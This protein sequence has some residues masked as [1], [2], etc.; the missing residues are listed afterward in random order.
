MDKKLN[1]ICWLWTPLK[2]VITTKKPYSYTYKDVNN[3]Y[4]MLKRFYK[5]PFKLL[6]ITDNPEGISKDIKIIPLWDELRSKGGCFTR[7]VVFKNG[8]DKVFGERFVSIDLDCVIVDD[9]TSLFDRK[10]DFVIWASGNPKNPY[11]G[12]LWML[13]ANSRVQVYNNF[14]ANEWVPNG[15]GRFPKGTDQAQIAKVLPKASTWSEEDGIYNYRYYRDKQIPNNARIIFFNGNFHPRQAYIQKK[16]EVV[17]KYYPEKNTKSDSLNICCFYWQG[18]RRSG[19]DDLNLVSKYINNLYIGLINNLTIPF[20]F[21][22]FIQKDLKL[23]GISKYVSI[24]PFDSPTYKGRLPKMKIYDKSIGLDGRIVMLDLDILITGNIDEMFSYTGD[25]MTRSSFKQSNR[26]GGD[27]VFFKASKNFPFWDYVY[28]SHPLL[29]EC[30]GNER[31]LYRK[32]FDNNPDE[33]I[34]YVQK[35]YPD[36]LFSYKKHFKLMDGLP[37]NCRILSCHGRP[38]VHRISDV[39]IRKLWNQRGTIC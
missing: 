29:N 20:S 34:D 35:K 25:F 13:K 39:R 38:R 1:F 32:Y 33:K 10:E 37:E 21:Y 28:H 5:K 36:Q 23:K 15:K 31:I 2:G 3:L 16:H 8:M 9:I 18:D 11:C 17:R 14:K 12:S 30:N 22:C 24:I 7:I 6:C 4:I 19:W 27:L 26:S